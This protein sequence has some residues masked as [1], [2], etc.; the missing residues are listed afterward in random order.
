VSCQTG[1]EVS[2][3]TGCEVSCQDC[4]TVCE[5]STCHNITINAYDQYNN[6]I[7]TA[8]YV[9]GNY[10]GDAGSPIQVTEGQHTIG[11][12]WDVSY[13]GTAH[14]AHFDRFPDYGEEYENPVT[15]NVGSDLEIGASYC[16]FY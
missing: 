11:V 10:A 4:Q 13:D 8:V 2:C 3:Q 6:S 12:D 14:F 9:D 5:T 7:P 16:M 15:I 1:C